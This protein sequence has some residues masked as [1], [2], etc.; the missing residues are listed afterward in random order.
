MQRTLTDMSM[1]LKVTKIM[2]A[3]IT[4]FMFTVLARNLHHV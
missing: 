1:T 4:S 3:S 2:V